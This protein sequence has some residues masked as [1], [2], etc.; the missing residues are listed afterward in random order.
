MKLIVLFFTLMAEIAYG[1]GSSV[2]VS[3]PKIRYDGT[4]YSFVVDVKNTS[5][6]RIKGGICVRLYDKDNFEIE[7]GFGGEVNFP[8]NASES[9][10]GNNLYVTPKVASEVRM[11]KFY[12]AKYRCSDS[13]GE[14]ISNV[15]VVKM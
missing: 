2:Q 11:A 6:T 13:E 4:A 12:F 14:A 7:N 5:A 1:A 9:S 8:A 10:A 3:N 15:V